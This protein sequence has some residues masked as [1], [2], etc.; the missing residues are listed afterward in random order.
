MKRKKYVI[1]S[2]KKGKTE[3]FC[4]RNDEKVYQQKIKET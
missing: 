3:G 1:P 2:T 4:L